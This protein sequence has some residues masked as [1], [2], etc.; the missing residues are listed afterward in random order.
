MRLR[1][2]PILS[3]AFAFNLISIINDETPIRCEKIQVSE[4]DQCNVFGERNFPLQ[5]AS[6]LASALQDERAE[7]D[8]K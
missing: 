8:G 1:I 6:Q 7:T 4:D 3:G 5:N 2:I